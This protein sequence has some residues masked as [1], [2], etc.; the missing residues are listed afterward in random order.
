MSQRCVMTPVARDQVVVLETM[1]NMCASRRQAHDFFAV[2]FCFFFI[3]TST[4]RLASYR[5]N[6]DSLGEIKLTISLGASQ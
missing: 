5:G 3:S 2:C 1:G 6:I 4:F